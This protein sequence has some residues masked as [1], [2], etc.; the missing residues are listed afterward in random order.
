MRTRNESG[1]DSLEIYRFLF[2]QLISIYFTSP[3]VCFNFSH[4]SYCLCVAI[5]VKR[6]Q[7]V[8]YEWINP[9]HFPTI[10]FYL[11]S[12]MSSKL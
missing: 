3:A 1:N 11:L 10:A 4:R 7:S 9:Q 12:M 8:L 5:Y 6:V 2:I